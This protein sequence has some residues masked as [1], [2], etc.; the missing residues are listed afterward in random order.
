VICKNC[1]HENDEDAKFCENCGSKITQGPLAHK[2]TSEPK[3][4]GWSTT[5]KALIIAIVVLIIILGAA[6][7]VLLK[8]NSNPTITSTNNTTQPTNITQSSGIPVSQVPSLAQSITQS[9]V[10]F[11]TIKFGGVTLDRN[12]CLYITARA[13]VMLNKGETGN[14]P[15]NQYGNP[16]NPYGTISSA[17]IAK[18]DYVSMAQ[19]SSTWMDKNGR[20]PNYVGITNPGQPDLS[21]YDVLNLYAKVL[22]AYKNTGQLPASMQIP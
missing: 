1:G 13:I 6:I 20:A 22:T 15:I 3:N 16:D 12:Q 11:S 10:G 14:I 4:E 8:S 19:R 18:S 9:G 21:T 2:P 5:S 7:G 17:N